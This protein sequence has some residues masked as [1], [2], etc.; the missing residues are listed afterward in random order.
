[1]TKSSTKKPKTK[2][3]FREGPVATESFEKIMKAIFQAP[4]IKRKGK[5]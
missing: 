1:V 3:E 5:D 2:V 4:K